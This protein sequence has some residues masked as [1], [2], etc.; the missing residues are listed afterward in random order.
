[1]PVILFFQYCIPNASSYLKQYSL[2]SVLTN[3]SANYSSIS[4]E[5]PN[6][7]VSVQPQDTTSVTSLDTTGSTNHQRDIEGSHM[8]EATMNQAE[9]E[10]RQQAEQ[11]HEQQHPSRRI[12]HQI[13]VLL[14]IVTC[15]AAALMVVAQIMGLFVYRSY[16]PIAY[17]LHLYIF[18]LCIVVVLVE[19]EWTPIGRESF[20]FSYWLTRGLSYTFIGVLGLETN[21]TAD[22]TNPSDLIENFVKVV[23]WLMFGMGAT[24]FILGLFCIQVIYTRERKDYT[25]RC[26]LAKQL[27]SN[28]N[29]VHSTPTVVAPETATVVAPENVTIVAPETATAVAPENVTL[30]APETATIV[31]PKPDAPEAAIAV[32]IVPSP[33]IRSSL[34]SELGAK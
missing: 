33:A 2:L 6:P 18:L 32:A 26:T 30:I 29:A 21:D 14:S 22:W 31:A 12:L 9:E 13:I 7:S 27:R 1:L 8:I 19:C 16:G 28:R 10:L 25:D 34:P 15:I 23:A 24:Y 4:K 17:V 11:I 3:A 5:H 20:I